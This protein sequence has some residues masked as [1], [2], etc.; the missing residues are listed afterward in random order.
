MRFWREM[1][2]ELSATDG[3]DNLHPVSWLKLVLIEAAAWHQFF[4]DLYRNALLAKVE[5]LH[6]GADGQVVRDLL[7]ISIQIY[8]HGGPS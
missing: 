3:L 4:V 1:G 5:L 8:L 7:F 6:Q 2:G